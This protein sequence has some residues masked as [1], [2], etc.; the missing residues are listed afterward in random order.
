MTRKSSLIAVVGLMVLF[1]LGC[2]GG[3]GGVGETGESTG[4]ETGGGVCPAN[5]TVDCTCLGGASGFQLCNAEG[6]G[7]VAACECTD[8]ETGT[9]ETGTEETGTE[10][11]GTEETGTEETGTEETGTE[12]TGESGEESG[13][14]IPPGMS[15]TTISVDPSSVVQANTTRFGINVGGYS[16]YFMKN[17]IPNPG[18][19]AGVHRSMVHVGA[20]STSNVVVDKHGW[21]KQESGYWEGGEFR[22]LTGPAAGRTGT[23]ASFTANG[24]YQ[25]TLVDDGPAGPAPNENDILIVRRDVPGYYADLE[26]GS[27]EEVRPGSPG[28]QSLRLTAGQQ[29]VQYLDASYR[30]IEMDMDKEYIVR[31]QWRFHGWVKGSPG[32]SVR[33]LFYRELDKTNELGWTHFLDKTVTFA[34]DGWVEVD[35]SFFVEDGLDPNT[36]YPPSFDGGTFLWGVRPILGIRFDAGEEN[37]APIFVDD[38]SLVREDTSTNPTEYNDIMVN[39]LK[40]YQPG[41]LRFWGGQLGQSLDQMLSPQWSRGSFHYRLDKMAPDRWTNSLHEFLELC[42]EVGSN[43]WYVFPPSLR[44]EELDHFIEYLASPADGDHPWAE[45]RASM[46]QTEPWTTVFDRIQLEFGNETWGGGGPGDPFGGS[47]VGYQL[48]AAVTPVFARMKAHPDFDAGVFQLMAPGQASNNYMNT[49]LG[50]TGDH[51]DGVSWAPYFGSLSSYANEAEI[52]QP[53]LALP[54]AM[55]TTGVIGRNVGTAHGFDPSTVTGNYEINFTS[56]G[57]DSPM[58]VRNRFV[59]GQVGALALPLQLLTFQRD[60]GLETQCAF[61]FYGVCYRINNNGQGFSPYN[62]DCVRVWGMVRDLHNTPRKRP[63][64]L[65]TELTN[66]AVL[67]S[68]VTTTHAGDDPSWWQEPMNG[69][70][71][72]LEVKTL[73]SF[74]FSE[75]SSRGLVLFNLDLNVAHGVRLDLVMTGTSSAERWWIANDDIGAWNE[76]QIEVEIEHAAVEEFGDGLELVL[77]PH[78]IH[79]IRWEAP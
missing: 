3:G 20:G 31:G 18:F 63:T 7:F 75:G 25:F 43:P 42:A 11:T 5:A 32:T 28:T 55:S 62:W 12:E 38:V 10:E 15:V 34:E 59:A 29:Y 64:F 50:Q 35:E 41:S 14:E 23:I 30:D 44:F 71:E 21:T 6:T 61:T 73:Q 16:S 72:A 65:G 4:E 39:M 26:K 40:D 56:V 46:G 45:L 47:S 79:A 52:Y 24:S 54:Q 36:P 68:A 17:L 53:V 22:F 2:G 77:P 69:I 58:E 48:G 37:T 49:T 9:E 13:G 8:E 51:Y 78:S 74:A 66:K 70:E 1:T 27:T 67:G 33:L 76:H 60:H 57:G 19:E